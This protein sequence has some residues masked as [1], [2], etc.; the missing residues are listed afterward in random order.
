MH[1][2]VITATI[3]ALVV[4]VAP[5][6]ANVEDD[7]PASV[8]GWLR[9]D[10]SADGLTTLVVIKPFGLS[11]WAQAVGGEGFRVQHAAPQALKHEGRAV[12]SYRHGRLIIIAES[13]QSWDFV[14]TPDESLV[15]SKSQGV[16]RF[17]VP[18]VAHY[19][20]DSVQEVIGELDDLHVDVPC[21]RS[22]GCGTCDQ[23]GGESCSARCDSGSCSVSCGG[24]Y[25]ACC[26][27]PGGCRCCR[28]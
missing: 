20:G 10:T 7:P 11:P 16:G 12:V 18:G 9:M 22:A 2:L 8:A 23:G 13:H 14:V 17:R 1:P 27:C 4:G 3:L 6:P 21:L 19:W 5:R 24:G 26:N 28:E 15:T 25:T